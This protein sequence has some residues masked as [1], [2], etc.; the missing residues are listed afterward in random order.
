[1][2]QVSKKLQE[3]LDRLDSR[4]EELEQVYTERAR[5][6]YLSDLAIK[7]EAREEATGPRLFL[8]E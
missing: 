2:G 4:I 5:I 1:M 3:E 8:V 6:C 7:V